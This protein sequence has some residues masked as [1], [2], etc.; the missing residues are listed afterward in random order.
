VKTRWLSRVLQFFSVPSSRHGRRPRYRPEIDSLEARLAPASWSGPIP[1]GTVWASG[2]V[3]TI[4]NG[5]NVPLGST[6]TIQPGAIVQFNNGTSLPIDGTLL[7]QGTASQMIYFTSVNDNSPPPLGGSNTASNGNWGDILFNSDSTGNMLVDTVIRYGGGGP[8]AEVMDMG[9]PL[10]MSSSVV[11]NSS[12]AGVRITQANPTLGSDTIQSNTG[13]AISMD[14]ASTPTITTPTLSNNLINGVYLDGNSITSN[15]SWNNPSI[16]Y[17]INGGITVNAGA[18]LIIGAGQIVKVKPGFN[19]LFINGTV[20]AN[21]ASSQPVLFTSLNDSSAADAGAT[22]NNSSSTGAAG[23]YN[24]LYFNT[25]STGNVL[26]YVTVLYGGSDQYG[27][28]VDD[29]AAL[30]LTNST[31]SYSETSGLRIVGSNPTLRQSET[32]TFTTWPCTC[33]RNMR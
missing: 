28:I 29:D 17:A 15:I 26:N 27:A 2:Q 8:A 10:T 12:S 22:N 16:V 23:D 24:G 13:A 25:G 21:G 1:N 33:S 4:M 7:A 32:I 11:S 19:G 31:L 18:T 3:Q 9:A 5:A 6:L 30:T 14:D 20:Q